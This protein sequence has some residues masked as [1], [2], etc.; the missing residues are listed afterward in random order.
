MKSLLFAFAVIIMDAMGCGRSSSHYNKELNVYPEKLT[1]EN[2]KGAYGVISV[3]FDSRWNTGVSYKGN[4]KWLEILPTSGYGD[5]NIR[6]TA[7]S[8]NESNYERSC[9]LYV[10][11]I[12]QHQQK[13]IIVTQKCE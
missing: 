9:T 12:D 4:E 13:M 5:A 7:L 8:S 6:I 2:M 10:T 3:S 1:L 11:D